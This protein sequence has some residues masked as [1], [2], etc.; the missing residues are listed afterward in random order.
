MF[1]MLYTGTVVLLMTIA[2]VKEIHKTSVIVFIS[3]LLLYIKGVISIDEAFAGFSN[4]G[5]L[6]VAILFIIPFERMI[7][8]GP[9]PRNSQGF[10]I[11]IS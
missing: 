8:S 9:L 3:M 2:L 10:R 11:T 6:T 7:T 1:S 5:M 4:H